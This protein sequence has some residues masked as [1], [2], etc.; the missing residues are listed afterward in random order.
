MGPSVLT[1][2]REQAA[3]VGQVDQ[4]LPEGSRDPWVRCV[5]GD[6]ERGT[7]LVP[8]TIQAERPQLPEDGI[9]GLRERD[10]R[11]GA[12]S[13]SRR[14][15]VEVKKPDGAGVSAC[16]P[17]CRRA[18][19]QFAAAIS[20]Q[21]PEGCERIPE[22]G[23]VRK[24]TESALTTRDRQALPDRSVA[25][26]EQHGHRTARIRKGAIVVGPDGELRHAVPVEIAQVRK[27][28]G[29]VVEPDRMHDV[30]LRDRLELLHLLVAGEAEHPDDAVVG[31]VG[32]SDCQ[33]DVSVALEVPEARER[34]AEAALRLENASEASAPGADLPG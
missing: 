16:S 24:R 10:G 25:G 33:V 29:E 26:E 14:I 32:R 27:R 13:G 19:D 18:D 1:L 5:G 23:L 31:A 9:A 12:D 15:A 7:W 4:D 8:G 3:S 22:V 21:V 28:G 34:E 11:R 30:G 20:I 6:D 2:E 17:V